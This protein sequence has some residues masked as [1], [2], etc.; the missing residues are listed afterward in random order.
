MHMTM[1]TTFLNLEVLTLISN[2]IQILPIRGGSTG[3]R[4]QKNLIIRSSRDTVSSGS[5]TRLS[6]FPPLCTLRFCHTKRIC[7]KAQPLWSST[8]AHD[9]L[10][11]PDPAADY[12]WGKIFKD[13]QHFSFV[14]S[15]E[16]AESNSAN[17]GPGII[18]ACTRCTEVDGAGPT[19]IS[20]LTRAL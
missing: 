1:S 17:P 4:S 9:K 5:Y 10:E 6:P 20:F 7:D 2:P 15:K 8:P 13:L 11:D 18:P 14:L 12:F 3:Q 16:C 19:D